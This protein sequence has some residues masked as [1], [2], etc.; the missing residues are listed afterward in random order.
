M[1]CVRLF[2]ICVA[3]G[4]R[5]RW[6]GLSKDMIGEQRWIRNQRSP[7]SLLHLTSISAYSPSSSSTTQT[8]LLTI[9]DLAGGL[10][11]YLGWLPTV[12]V[13]K[14]GLTR[15]QA[16]S[17]LIRLLPDTIARYRMQRCLG[18]VHV[19]RRSFSP[20]NPRSAGASILLDSSI[21]S[22]GLVSPLTHLRCSDLTL[23]CIFPSRN[24]LRRP[25]TSSPCCDLPSLAANLI[26]SGTTLCTTFRSQ[27]RLGSVPTLQRVRR[28][29]IHLVVVV[30]RGRR[31]LYWF[32]D[33]SSWVSTST[34]SPLQHS[35]L[36]F[37]WFHQPKGNL[38]YEQSPFT[39]TSCCCSRLVLSL[40]SRGSEWV[41]EFSAEV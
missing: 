18:F 5:Y 9:G 39:V 25:Q 20:R 7:L 27:R 17:A 12:I 33:R 21:G 30:N 23:L 26:M 4:W 31:K 36:T 28:E 35:D 19:F 13:W 37:I 34:Y 10:C 15:P 2:V 11:P 14:I 3:I 32:R 6:I 41:V 22:L 1:N 38:R 8:F 29:G 40:W 16:C 24:L